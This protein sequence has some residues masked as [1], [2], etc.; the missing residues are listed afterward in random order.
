MIPVQTAVSTPTPQ[1][2]PH[3]SLRLDLSKQPSIP[4]GIRL[5]RVSRRDL[6]HNRPVQRLRRSE[7][8][9]EL[10]AFS[11]H[12]DVCV[13]REVSRVD[14]GRVERICAINVELAVRE[15]MLERGLDGDRVGTLG[16]AG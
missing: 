13:M 4:L 7:L 16:R 8:A 6:L 14:H 15:W 5:D 10:E 11:D 1:P 12:E 9:R 3:N 2:I